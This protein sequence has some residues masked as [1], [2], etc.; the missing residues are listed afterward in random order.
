MKNQLSVL[1]VVFA[2]VLTL[3]SVSA[4]ELKSS[5]THTLKNKDWF[6][7]FEMGSYS[8]N[9]SIVFDDIP[10]ERPFYQLK[11]TLLAGKIGLGVRVTPRSSLALQYA[12]GPRDNLELYAHG[13]FQD[14]NATIRSRFLSLVMGREFNVNVTDS[15]DAKFGITRATFENRARL[16]QT[17]DTISRNTEVKPVIAL[18]YRRAFSQ[19]WSAGIEATSYFLSDPGTVT[20]VAIGLR[21]DL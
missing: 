2:V 10:E 7:S 18:G 9:A 4:E 1:L 17:G 6:L 19:R 16:G 12:R 11:Q 5:A 20:S 3:G 13:E 21:C 15:V 14:T 8:D